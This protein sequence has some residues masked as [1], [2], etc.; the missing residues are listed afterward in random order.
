MHKGQMRRPLI[1][2]EEEVSSKSLAEPLK[3]LLSLIIERLDVDGSGVLTVKEL[4]K[5]L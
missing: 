5:M 3:M 1:W 4:K 2:Q